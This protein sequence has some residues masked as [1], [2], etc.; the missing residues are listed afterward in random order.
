MQHR[1]RP[2]KT[3][4]LLVF[5]PAVLLVAALLAVFA[6]NWHYSTILEG[7]DKK[8]V[9]TSTLTGAL[10][11]PED[12]DALIVAARGGADPD[13]VEATPQYRRN[14]D[15]IERILT[16]LNLTYLYTQA[17]ADGSDI[18][19]VLD[20]A[21]GDEHSP[22]GAGDDLSDETM[23][24]IQKTEM[25]GTIYVS[26]IEYQ[27]QWGLLKTAVAPV[28]DGEGRLSSTAGADVNISLILVATQNALFA[29]TLIG[30]GSIALCLIITFAIVRYVAEPIEALKD[31]A[32]IIAAGDSAG[33]IQTK[34]PAEVTQLS[35][36]LSQMANKF[37]QAAAE[38]DESFAAQNRA[39]NAD[40]VSRSSGV[41]DTRCINLLA[42]D[43]RRIVWLPAGTGLL[44]TTLAKRAM[45]ELAKRFAENS[46]LAADWRT[47][48]DTDNG[49]CFKI[50][51]AKGTIELFGAQ[52]ADVI[53]NDTT[54]SIAPGETVAFCELSDRIRLR[55]GP[56]LQ[57]LDDHGARGETP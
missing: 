52:S 43:E 5:L 36:A 42:D 24:G 37:M 48:A 34:G 29:S 40:L 17:T 50:S 16:K 21:L 55:G 11:D 13:I 51:R 41:E 19:Y 32:L 53:R 27:E 7:F 9:T 6:Y 23:A 25:D 44:G 28:Y 22:I 49:A 12:H 38:R 8:L 15:P 30:L 14:A 39:A 2:I 46:K 33:S 45:A 57:L 1:G 18:V 47:L 35:G 56:L 20:G 54:I 26:P 31:Q 4:L 10:V 3:L